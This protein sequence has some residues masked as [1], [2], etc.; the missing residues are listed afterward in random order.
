M[1]NMMGM[2]KWSGARVL[3][4]GADGFIGSHL[5]ERLVREGAKVR[6][7]CLYNSQGSLG[8]LD[9]ASPEVRE[10]IDVRLGDIRDG[11]FV[12]T[13]CEDIDVVFHL[14]ALI[15]IPYSYLA[16]ESF[17]ETNVRGTLNVLEAGR[18]TGVRRIVQTST[19]EVYGTPTVLP[20]RESHPLCAQ[21]PYAASKVAADQ[22]ALSYHLS[23]ATPVVVLRP[24]NT[25]G[26]R[27]STRAVT[28]TILSQL[29]SGQKQVKLGRLDTRRD[30]TFVS[31]VVQG[32]LL[33]GMTANVEGHVIHLGTGRSVSIGDLFALSCRLV[34]VDAEVESD[35]RRMR[36]GPSEVMVLQSDPS[37]AASELGWQPDVKL[38]EGIQKTIDWMR[39]NL[40]KYRA[41]V[42]YA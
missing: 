14:A 3:V 28:A 19:S 27:Q 23:F 34:G 9:Q 5:A 2:T 40:G 38:E 16:P 29:L 12:Q 1:F 33:A 15:A 42:L 11:R 18:R 25:F 26:P 7:F 17:Y 6:A 8:W 30:L 39:S 24:F 20:I 32:F 22:M 4:T 36:P 37:L 13:A 31:D 35:S 10:A 41:D 21:S